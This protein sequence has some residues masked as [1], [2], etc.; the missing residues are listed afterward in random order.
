MES[1]KSATWVIFPIRLGSTKRHAQDDPLELGAQWI[2]TPNQ[3]ADDIFL[4]E[5]VPLSM[6]FIAGNHEDYQILQ[7]PYPSCSSPKA[8][9]HW[10]SVCRVL[11]FFPKNDVGFVFRRWGLSKGKEHRLTQQNAFW[12]ILAQLRVGERNNEQLRS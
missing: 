9:R 1:C 7:K 6:W 12:G 2:V 8:I 3:Q 10:F 11:E 5:D 4:S